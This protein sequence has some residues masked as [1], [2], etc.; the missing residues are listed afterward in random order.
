MFYTYYDLKKPEFGHTTRPEKATIIH[1]KLAGV[2]SVYCVK[3]RRG[4][5]FR[6]TNIHERILYVKRC[7]YGNRI[8]NLE[9][10]N[11][12]NKYGPMWFRVGILDE[13]V[14]SARESEATF[15]AKL[16]SRLFVSLHDKIYHAES[17]YNKKDTVIPVIYQRSLVNDIGQGKR[18]GDGVIIQDWRKRRGVYVVTI[19]ETTISYVR[20]TNDMHKKYTDI[21]FCLNSDST[22]VYPSFK[23]DYIKHG[24]RLFWEFY[25][26]DSIFEAENVS[27]RLKGK[28][29]IS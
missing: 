26:T 10:Q 12:F 13:I 29:S 18:R 9:L 16:D 28:C 25:E 14:K 20:Y 22:K 23:L 1:G 7:L 15:Q 6:S 11:D 19:P 2:A 17:T 8:D 5:Y 4:Y 24:K 3:T 27:E 21:L